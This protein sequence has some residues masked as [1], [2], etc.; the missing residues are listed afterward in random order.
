MGENVG[1]VDG[2]SAGLQKALT[3]GDAQKITCGSHHMA[4]V[5]Q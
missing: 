3:L 5:G 2:T 1:N 4:G